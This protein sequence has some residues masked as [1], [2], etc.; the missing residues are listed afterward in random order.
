[1]N[2]SAEVLHTVLTQEI[3]KLDSGTK[4]ARWLDAA[5]LFPSYGFGN[6]V[7][8][9]LQMPQANWVA[10]AQ[11]WERMGRGVMKNRAIKILAPVRSRVLFEDQDGRPTM[12]PQGSIQRGI[13]GF[14]VANVWDVAHTIGPPIS[15]PPLVSPGTTGGLWETLLRD[16]QAKGFT[17]DVQRT[18]PEVDSYTDHA[19][20]RIV[21][22]SQLDPVTT[23]ARLAHEVGHLRMHSATAGPPEACYGITQLEAD[24]FAHIALARHGRSVQPPSFEGVL[25]RA[26]LVEPRSP[27][28]VV[29]AVGARAV[30]AA[31]RFF[32]A[33][34]QNSSPVP[35]TVGKAPA[36]DAGWQAQYTGPEL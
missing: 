19:V 35:R 31:R 32:E 9:S 5:A 22:S 29:K 23:V 4:W 3:R 25:R 18:G 11:G 17:V 6:I 34:G 20:R 10:A 15:P 21:V 12:D 30:I 27:E 14:K 26:A 33:T 13:I 24:S 7:L 36:Q 1:M 2:V 16:S 28:P 8:I